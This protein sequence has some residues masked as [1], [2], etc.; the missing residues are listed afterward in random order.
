MPQ[1]LETCIEPYLGSFAK[2]FAAENYTEGT[3]RTY[4]SILRK[5]GHAMDVAGVSPT[6]L[7]L[8]IAERL[9]REIPRR[10]NGTIWPHRL[11]RRFAQHLLDIGVTKPVPLTEL[12]RAHAALLADF[13]SYLARQ[14]GLSPR[15][16]QHAIG[17]ARRFLDYRFGAT[18]ID[19]GSVRPADV[20]SFLEHVRLSARRDKTVATHLRNFLRYLFGCG[21]T[22]TNLALCVPKVAK[23]WDARLPRH[24]SP[25]G[26]EAVL[27]C[28]RDNPQH[29]ARDY[30][31]LVLMARLGLRAAEVIAIQLDDIDWR[32]GELTVRGKGKLHYRV[33]I[34][35]E[36]GDALSR[37]LRDERPPATCRTM[38][39]IHRAPHRPFKDGQIVNA[40]LK[41]ALQATGQ[42][43]ATPYVGSHLLRHSLATQLV[44]TGASLDEVR[45]VLRHR[46]RSSTMIYAR[47]D[48]NGLRSVVQPWPVAG[49]AQ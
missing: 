13:E 5:V 7:T 49:D 31:M 12:E 4:Q 39:V 33:P 10:M 23:V 44:N 9:G 16:I 3:V 43:P 25:D 42:K 19:L 29:G 15:S 35:A 1:Y 36:V 41:D 26:V 2:S 28:V 18:T 22:A 24:L 30:A 48:I 47:L 46:A 21:A 17:F 14:R 8:D 37:Y 40:I 34:T 20:I 6:A 45:D 38:F 11:A 32:S 27:V